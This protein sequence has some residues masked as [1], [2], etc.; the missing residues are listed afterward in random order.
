MELE[1]EAHTEAFAHREP[2][3]AVHTP[4]ERSVHHELHPAGFVEET[5]EHDVGDRGDDTERVSLRANVLV[6]LER[7]ER[8]ERALAFEPRADVSLRGVAHRVDEIGPEA[9]HLFGQLPRA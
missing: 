5:L 1:V 9:A 3:R 6:D 2:E 7:S 8:A 4:T